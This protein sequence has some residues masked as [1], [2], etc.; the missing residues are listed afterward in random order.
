MELEKIAGEM[1]SAE[2]KTLSSNINEL[3]DALNEPSNVLKAKLPEAVF[4]EFFLPGLSGEIKENDVTLMKYIEYAGTPYSEVDIIDDEGKVIFTC[5]PLYKRSINQL[6]K[7][8]IPYTE[9]AGT[10]ELKKTRM[11]SEATAY[12][13]EAVADIRSDVKISKDTSE[14]KW[15]N[16]FNRYKTPNTETAD[17]N[18]TVSDD[19]DLDEIIDY[20]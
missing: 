11:A 17:N 3:N 16:I 18:P 1:E 19:E 13:S 8:P 7:D 4:K 6:E 20:D 10:Y 12:M 9:I 5:P 2:L 14:D 15:N